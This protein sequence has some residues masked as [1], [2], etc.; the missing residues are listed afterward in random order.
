LWLPIANVSCNFLNIRFG[1]FTSKFIIPYLKGNYSL[2][3]GRGGKVY[4]P[5][6]T[7]PLYP[8]PLFSEGL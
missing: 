4:Q 3:K 8:R 5:G 1:C 7:P 6:S 2:K